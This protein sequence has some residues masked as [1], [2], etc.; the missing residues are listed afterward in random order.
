[1]MLQTKCQYSRLCGFRQDDKI[2]SYFSYISLCKTCYPGQGQGYFGPLEHNLNK[3]CSGPLDDASYQITRLALLFQTRRFFMFP[4]ISLC[5]T[6]DRG[7][8][9]FG[10]RDIFDQT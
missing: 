3:L 6:R 7:E 1:M 2:L 4:Y 8:P 5:N 10:H 9:I